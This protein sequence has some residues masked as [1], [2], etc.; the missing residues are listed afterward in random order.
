MPTRVHAVLAGRHPFGGK[1]IRQRVTAQRRRRRNLA[2]MPRLAYEDTS[3]TPVTL[4]F[5]KPE[6]ARSLF[7]RPIDRNRHFWR[8]LSQPGLTPPRIST[9]RRISTP[10]APV[11]GC[12][13]RRKRSTRGRANDRPPIFAHDLS[14][15]PIDCEAAAIG[16]RLQ[17]PPTP[18][19][20]GWRL[21]PSRPAKGSRRVRHAAPSIESGR[22]PSERAERRTR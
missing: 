13:Q 12:F 8:A 18:W 22:R 7:P 20:R 1:S 2:L 4:T 6:A 14:C 15:Q 21:H 10:L 9:R 5:L 16:L 17:A 3:G 19:Q 11:R